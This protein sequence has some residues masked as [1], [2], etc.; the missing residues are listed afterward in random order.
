[1]CLKAARAPAKIKGADRLIFLNE[2]LYLISLGH[3]QNVKITP[4]RL[5]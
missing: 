5:I 3:F 2:F 4:Q 1:M